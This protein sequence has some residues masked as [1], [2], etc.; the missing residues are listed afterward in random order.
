MKTIQLFILSIYVPIL[1]LSG[2]TSKQQYEA[3]SSLPETEK[4]A[5]LPI[6]VRYIAKA[7]KQVNGKARFDPK[8]NSFYE[9]AAKEFEWKYFYIDSENQTRYFLVTRPAPSLYKKRIAVGGKYK[10]VENQLSDYE[11]VFWTFK[12]KE[13]QLDNKALQLFEEM[14]KGNSLEKYYPQN[15]H[16]NEEWI[17]FPDATT[18]FDKD[19]LIWKKK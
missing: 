13:D 1:F 19:S 12:M 4:Q 8:F 15:T 2:C 14:V 9:N 11:E 10:F 5:V 17:E 7:P 18:Y 16:E 6:L 3:S